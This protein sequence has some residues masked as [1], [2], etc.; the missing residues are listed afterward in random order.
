MPNTMAARE[1]DHGRSPAERKPPLNVKEL[2]NEFISQPTTR[3]IRLL[4]PE[5]QDSKPLA[6]AS[7]IAVLHDGGWGHRG[8]FVP[9]KDELPDADSNARMKFE[10][11]LAM[12]TLKVITSVEARDDLKASKDGER[13]NTPATKKAAHL[14][15]VAATLSFSEIPSGGL[16][17][18]LHIKED[19]LPPAE[20]LQTLGIEANRTRRKIEQDATKQQEAASSSFFARNLY[21]PSQIG[22]RH[23]ILDREGEPRPLTPSGL[24]QPFSWKEVTDGPATLAEYIQ[25]HYR[26]TANRFSL[27]S[28]PEEKRGQ[29]KKLEDLSDKEFWQIA[30]IR[31]MQGINDFEELRGTAFAGYSLSEIGQQ[32]GM[33]QEDPV[34]RQEHMSST[35]AYTNEGPAGKNSGPQVRG[36]FT[37]ENVTGKQMVG[38]IAHKLAMMETRIEK[39]LVFPAQ[40]EDK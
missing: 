38:M 30:A 36:F 34:Y 23:D 14:P 6:Y 33:V 10:Y 25:T 1:N 24:Q 13:V 40:E 16:A 18:D 17:V 19:G 29:V 21:A 11:G 22:L 35:P 15:N 3:R 12:T 27:P 39:G 5:G 31:V 2:T 32:L 4:G 26:Q 7:L 8:F 20:V 9:V 37:P 28:L